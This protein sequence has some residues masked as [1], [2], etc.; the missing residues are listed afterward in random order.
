MRERYGDDDRRDNRDRKD[1]RID[2]KANTGD[3]GCVSLQPE[4]QTYS[5]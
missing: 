3:G 4:V 2:V 1:R 5:G